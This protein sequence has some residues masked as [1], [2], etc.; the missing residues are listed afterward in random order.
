[1]DG[2]GPYQLGAA[3]ATLKASPGLDAVTSGGPACPDNTVAQG[4]GVWKGVQLRFHK[5]GALFLAVNRSPTVPTPS[6]A[7]LGT[8]LTQLKTIYAA[9]P[10]ENLTHGAGAAY[11]VTTLTGGAL[12]FDLGSHQQVTDMIAGDGPYLR[13]TYLSGAADYC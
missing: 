11:L 5:D 2:A 9:I 8:T 13:A 4:I 6:G 7:W 10:G 1:M 3:L 12:L